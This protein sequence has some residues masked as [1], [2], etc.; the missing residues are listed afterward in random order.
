[1]AELNRAAGEAMVAAGVHAATDVTGFGLAGH[2]HEMLSASACAASINWSGVPTFA[3][4]VD[5]ARQWCRPARSFSVEDF[6]Q[7][8]LHVPDNQMG[9]DATAVLCDP[10]TSGGMLCAIPSEAAATFEEEFAARCGRT[11]AKIGHVID[12]ESGHIH[13]VE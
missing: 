9:E 5:L 13:V 3:E 6:A 1:M 2:L 8:F 7:P 11:P 10:Q 12:G 4:T